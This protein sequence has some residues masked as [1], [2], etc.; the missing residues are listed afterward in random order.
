MMLLPNKKMTLIAHWNCR[1]LLRNLG[2]IKDILNSFCPLALCVQETNMGPKNTNFLRQYKVVRQDRDTT[3][4]LSGGVEI[5]MKFNTTLQGIWSQTVLEA[6][7]VSVVSFKTVTVCSI[8]L[9]P[10]TQVTVRDLEELIEQLL[11]PFILV[12]DFN[13]HSSMWGSMTTD[14]R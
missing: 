10:H 1:G 11:K 9:P 14:T 2:D 3:G 4:C 7:V 5:I 13:A 6:V 12:G 8:Y